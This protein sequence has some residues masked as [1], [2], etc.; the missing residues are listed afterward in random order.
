M[1]WLCRTGQ[2]GKPTGSASE[3]LESSG[4]KGGALAAQGP[5]MPAEAGVPLYAPENVEALCSLQGT[6]LRTCPAVERWFW[7]LWAFGISKRSR[8]RSQ[9]CLMAALPGS[10][11]LAVV[12]QPLS[13]L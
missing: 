1:E 12:C 2:S 13:C 10:V 5:G 6:I 7:L 4:V 8:I 11:A 9:A 3:R